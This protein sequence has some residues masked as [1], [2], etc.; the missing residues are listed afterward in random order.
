MIR[1]PPRSTRT[2]TLLPYTTLFRSARRG[3]GRL[4]ADPRFAGG[5]GAGRLRLSGATG[6]GLEGGGVLVVGFEAGLIVG[7]ET[8]QLRVVD[9]AAQRLDGDPFEGLRVVAGRPVGVTGD[10]AQLGHL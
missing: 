7:V 5:L 3:A 1:R 9:V 4:R 6:R 2:D 10:Q 8:E